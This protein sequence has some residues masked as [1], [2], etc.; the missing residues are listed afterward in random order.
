VLEADDIEESL[1]PFTNASDT[2]LAL[3]NRYD[4]LDLPD[5]ACRLLLLYGLPG[6]T[7]LQE[8]FLLYRLAATSLLRDRLVTRL[9]QAVGRCTRSDTDYAVVIILEQRLVDFVLKSDTRTILHPEIQAPIAVNG[10]KLGRPLLGHTPACPVASR[11]FSEGAGW[12]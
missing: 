10:F 9:T 5:D 11:S 4:G 7:N 2:V 1:E 8:Q 12:L 6:G 3:A